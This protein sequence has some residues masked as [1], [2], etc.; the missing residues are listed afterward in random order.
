MPSPSQQSLVIL[1]S[2]VKKERRIAAKAEGEDSYPRGLQLFFFSSCQSILKSCQWNKSQ[3][4]WKEASENPQTNR[5]AHVTLKR[6]FSLNIFLLSRSPFVEHNN[7]ERL[8]RNLSQ[9][10]SSIFIHIPTSMFIF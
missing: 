9:R 5:N 10:D 6:K 7:L 3:K 8:T 4:G 1:H 2:H